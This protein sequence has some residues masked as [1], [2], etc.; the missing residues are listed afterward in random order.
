MR[1][2]GLLAVA[3]AAMPVAGAHADGV[4]VRELYRRTQAMIESVVDPAQGRGPEV[5]APPGNIDP[6]MAFEPPRPAGAMRV[7]R[8]PEPFAQQP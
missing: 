3:I 2:A 4:D 6:K 8:P 7:I 5:I 1:A